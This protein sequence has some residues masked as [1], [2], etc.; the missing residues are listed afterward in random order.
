MMETM[1]AAEPD[2]TPVEGATVTLGRKDYGWGVEAVEV[3]VAGELFLRR[4]GVYFTPCGSC[5]DGYSGSKPEFGGIMGGV[6][7]QCNGTGCRARKDSLA[8]VVKAV[9]RRFADR[10]RREKREAERVAKMEADGAAWREAHPALAE[11][12]AGISVERDAAYGQDT[13]A[14]DALYDRYGSFVLDLAAQAAYRGLS[15]AQTTSVVE[16]LDRADEEHAEKVAKSEASR[17]WGGEGEKVTGT[18]VVSV[19][20]VLEGD[21]GSRVF[22]VVTGTDDFEGVTFKIV[23]TG[24][25]LWATGRGDHVTVTGTV[26]GHD[27]Y[28]GVKQTILTRTKVTVE[29]KADDA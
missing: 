5:R 21:Y 7:F 14:M 13:E 23:G 1:T 15:E 24:K 25:T 22:M 11:R 6:C 27:N 28:E 2:F 10:A 17:Y 3:T 12:L 16:A 8:E 4:G 19:W 29:T 9:K 18:G 26:K 20:M